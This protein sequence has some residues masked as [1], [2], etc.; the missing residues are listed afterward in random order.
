MFYTTEL[1]W[2]TR[3]LYRIL[4]LSLCLFVRLISLH[5]QIR[6]RMKDALF[7]R[8]HKLGSSHQVKLEW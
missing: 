2:I 5:A 4:A 1:R 3:G 6:K 7:L 8:E